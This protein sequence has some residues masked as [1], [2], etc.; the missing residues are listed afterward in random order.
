MRL[1]GKNPAIERLRSNPKSIRQI[2]IQ[3]GFR[4]AAYIYKKA[5]QN[6]IP[7]IAV[8]AS[9]LWKMG[10]DKNTQGILVDVEDF[11]YTP[12]EDL[13]EAALHKK[14]C[15]VFLDGL[16]DPQNLGAVIRSL[17]CLGRFSVVL[18]AHG[19]VEIT[20]SV[21]RVASGGDN[22]VPVAKVT[23]LAQAVRSAKEA[24]I[25]VMGSV[26]ES[27]VNIF[28]AEFSFPLGL[29]VGSERQGIREGIRKLLDGEITIPLA[30][31]TLSF[32]VAQAATILCY[33]ITR[34]RKIR[35]DTQESQRP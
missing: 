21:L 31:E 30:M 14:R 25:H 26:V 28:D 1:F 5:K 13:L 9:R 16:N 34:Q 15:L 10:R 27:G 19:S 3:E 24:G 7:V 17:A 8:A 18:P 32:N 4:E 20:E 22:Y 12:Y 11:A 2:Y 33:E 23:N 29:V 35:Q 6:G